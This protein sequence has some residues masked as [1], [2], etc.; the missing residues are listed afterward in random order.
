MNGLLIVVLYSS[1]SLFNDYYIR[2]QKRKELSYIF[3]VANRAG[4]YCFKGK[5][6]ITLFRIVAR[7]LICRVA[8]RKRRVIKTFLRLRSRRGYRAAVSNEF[9]RRVFM[10]WLRKGVT[11]SNRAWQSS[12]ARSYIAV[13]RRL[14][15]EPM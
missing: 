7:N 12:S 3:T 2:S 14:Q 9:S 10:G 4:W 15:L 8:L 1:I 11:K 5:R 6:T 13:D